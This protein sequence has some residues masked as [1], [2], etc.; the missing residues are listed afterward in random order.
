MR[1]GMVVAK[2]EY[3]RRRDTTAQR[4]SNFK[5][6][7]FTGEVSAE[8]AS[9]VSRKIASQC[10]TRG[11]QSGAFVQGAL[12]IE[13]G[14]SLMDDAEEPRVVVDG[15]MHA[16]LSTCLVKGLRES[17]EIWEALMPGTRVNLNYYFRRQTNTDAP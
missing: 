12:S 2:G 14:K 5:I 13:I 17:G 3:P 4:L 6:T 7:V 16:Q 8:K 9:N 11:E 15:L 10:L 1:S